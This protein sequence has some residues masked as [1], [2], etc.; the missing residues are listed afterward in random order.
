[1]PVVRD[2]AEKLEPNVIAALDTAVLAAATE[3]V[4]VVVLDVAVL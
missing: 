2:T 1:V 4:A 3:I